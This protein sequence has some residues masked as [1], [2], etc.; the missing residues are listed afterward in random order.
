MANIFL[1][2]V[3]RLSIEVICSGLVPVC[4][5]SLLSCEC[6]VFLT[7]MQ[8]VYTWSQLS[9]SCLLWNQLKECV[10]CYLHSSLCI[11]MWLIRPI[12]TNIISQWN[13]WPLGSQMPALPTELLVSEA[14]TVSQVF[15]KTFIQHWLMLEF[16][17]S[18]I[19]FNCHQFPCRLL[20]L[21]VIPVRS[22]VHFVPHFG[23]LSQRCPRSM[24][25]VCLMLY[26]PHF[27][28]KVCLMCSPS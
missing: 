12:N 22:L 8:C 7:K 11:F 1:V 23:R 4:F 17:K 16:S 13:R 14:N 18:Q 6:S 28:Y 10:L 5:S 20:F 21:F 3:G 25:L 27:A 15:I 2:L 9:V 19:C 26:L 24:S